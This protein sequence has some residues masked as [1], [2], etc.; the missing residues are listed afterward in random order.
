MC[1]NTL[2]PPVHFFT[3]L[4]GFFP[5]ACIYTY[6]PNG[7]LIFVH[8]LVI[9]SVLC[10]C[11]PSFLF[12]LVLFVSSADVYLQQLVSEQVVASSRAPSTLLRLQSQIRTRFGVHTQNALSQRLCRLFRPF[13]PKVYTS[14]CS[15]V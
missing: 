3:S 8:S 14:F 1:V 9:H 10:V 4:G 13:V 2:G 7:L 11:A 12:F 5:P 6:C 15:P